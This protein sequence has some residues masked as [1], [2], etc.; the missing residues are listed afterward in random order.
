MERKARLY[1]SAVNV[2][3]IVFNVNGS[4]LYAVNT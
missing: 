4:K 2:S 1:N 3:K